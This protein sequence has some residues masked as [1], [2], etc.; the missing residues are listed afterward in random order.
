M[1]YSKE[2]ND[3]VLIFNVD[4]DKIVKLL[5]LFNDHPFHNKLSLL[6]ALLALLPALLGRIF[7]YKFFQVRSVPPP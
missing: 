6:P 7:L 5:R 4:V 3:G 2:E 1:L